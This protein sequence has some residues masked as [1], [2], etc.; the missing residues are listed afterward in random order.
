MGF[1]RGALLFQIDQ[2]QQRAP[3]IEPVAVG[4]VVATAGIAL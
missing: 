4:Y 2:S 3:M 1:A